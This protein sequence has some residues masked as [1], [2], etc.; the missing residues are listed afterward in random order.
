VARYRRGRVFGASRTD[1]GVEELPQEAGL[2]LPKVLALQPSDL[3]RKGGTLR[4]VSSLPSVPLQKRRYARAVN[5]TRTEYSVDEQLLIW[6]EPDPLEVASVL[7]ARPPRPHRSAGTSKVPGAP[8]RPAQI[9]A[10]R[11]S[12]VSRLNRGG[13]K[14][15]AVGCCSV[16]CRSLPGGPGLQHFLEGRG[17]RDHRDPHLCERRRNGNRRHSERTGFCA[18]TPRSD[19]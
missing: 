4:R 15:C 18:G 13:R 12:S 7:A 2:A 16:T 14:T 1:G 10:G 8:R 17:P 9:S 19:R 11:R 6:A 3:R 5:P